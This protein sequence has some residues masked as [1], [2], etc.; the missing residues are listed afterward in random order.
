MNKKT[1]FSPFQSP[2]L[3]DDWV[4]HPL[5]LWISDR[6]HFFLWGLL[7]LFAA[8]LFIYRFLSLQTLNAE[9]DFIQAANAFQQIEQNTSS[10][11]IKKTHIQ[12]LLAIMARHPELHAKYDGV[13]A[14]YF[15]IQNQ[16]SEAKQ[17]AKSTF[18]RVKPDQLNLYVN[19]AKTSLLISEG[20]YKEALMQAND[21]QKQLSLI[22]ENVVLSVY[23]LIRLALLHEQL[24][25]AS[26]AVAIWDQ[27][28][29]LNRN[30]DFSEA[31]LITTKLFQAG[32]INLEQFVEGR[33][34]QQKS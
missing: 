11:D 23:N 7:G 12:E 9:N 10:S 14:Q 32:Q 3:S 29:A 5:I 13:L 18:E 30:K 6:K 15:I 16:P 19:Y 22:P 34:N 27:L 26:E 1:T 8:L 2:S 24:N 25:Q 28:I 20:S 31:E 33:K 21:L 17:L 4:D